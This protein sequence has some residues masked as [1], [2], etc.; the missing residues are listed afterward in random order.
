MIHEADLF[1]MA[2]DTL[3]EVLSRVRTEQQWDIV[4]P[5]MFDVPDADRPRTIRQLVAHYAFDDSWVPDMLAGATMDDIGRDF[6]DGDLLGSDPQM[7]IVRISDAACAAARKV[8]DP[9]AVVHCSFGD[10]TT[11][12]YFMQINIVRCFLAHDVAFHLGSTACP[13]PEE[14][15]RPMWEATAPVADRWRS[16]GIFREPLPI[17]DDAS[18]RDRFLRAAGRDPHPVF[19]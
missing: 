4:I 6:F 1:V 16:L 19:H 2:E 10:V 14:L 18:W 8:T 3:V 17:P 9:D 15:A 5:A 11:S 13:L 7:A 12:E